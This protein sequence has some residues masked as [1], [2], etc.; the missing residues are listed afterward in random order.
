MVVLGNLEFDVVG[1]DELKNKLENEIIPIAEKLAD[2][3]NQIKEFEFELKI[4]QGE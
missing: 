1:V 3:L 4:K 2:L